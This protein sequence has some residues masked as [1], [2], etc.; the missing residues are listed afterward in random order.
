[1]AGCLVVLFLEIDISI[2]I[3]ITYIYIDRCFRSATTTHNLVSGW[4][5]EVWFNT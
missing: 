5:D 3:H 4:G 1:L 2:D